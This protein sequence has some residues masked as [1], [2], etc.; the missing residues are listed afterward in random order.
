MGKGATGCLALII[1]VITIGFL[2]VVIRWAAINIL[3]V[4]GIIVA[5]VGFISYINRK[6]FG[7]GS[8]WPITG[9]INGLVLTFSWLVCKE[10]MN[11]LGLT[12]LFLFFY[13]VITA[14]GMLIKKRKAWKKFSGLSLALFIVSMV[15]ILN[16]PKI[17]IS[18]PHQV[19][20]EP[21]K[22][23]IVKKHVTQQKKKT[24]N[25]D[26]QKD[27]S[28]K[29]PADKPNTGTTDQP[30]VTTQSP[31]VS[32]SPNANQVPVTL[33]ATVDGDTI[34]VVYNGHEETVRYLLVD[35]PEE[36]KPGTCV[37]PYALAAANRNKQLV[38][39][40]KLSLEFEH[41][42]TDK[43]GRLLAYVFVNGSSV[44]ETLL[45]EGYARV[46]Y[47]RASIQIFKSV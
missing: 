35:T 38:N 1:G 17:E 23:E 5:I 40:G 34:K 10:W 28:P 43:Y 44:Q 32:P 42:R 21:R 16:A 37:Q 25:K 30:K 15:F 2:Y 47:L 20:E 4:I 6:K 13:F 11:A 8:Y 33:V 41:S 19:S 22:S 45:K 14:F 3:G 24:V 7:T 39:S 9:I 18:K 26:E 36:K 27:S 46:A 31:S 29:E 12:F